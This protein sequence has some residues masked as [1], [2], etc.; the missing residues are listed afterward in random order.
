MSTSTPTHRT[1]PTGPAPPPGK[2]KASPEDGRIEVEGEVDSNKVGRHWRCRL[3]HDGSLSD[4]GTKKTVAPSG[5]FE[6]RRVLVNVSGDDRIVSGPATR[7]VTR[8]A[9]GR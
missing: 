8:S 3:K 9:A 1:P 6:V 2:L 7:G 4:K 5:S